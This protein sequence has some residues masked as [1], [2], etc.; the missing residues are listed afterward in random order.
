M[1]QKAAFATGV[2]PNICAFH[3]YTG[4]S[5][6]PYQTQARQ[7]GVRTGVEPRAFTPRLTSRLRAL[8]AQ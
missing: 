4:N 8:Y 2:P 1:A 6:F 7:F 5:T 3:R